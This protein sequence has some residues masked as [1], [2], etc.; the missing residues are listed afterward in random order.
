MSTTISRD[1]VITSQRFVTYKFEHSKLV[2]QR[3]GLRFVNPH[4][5]CVQYELLV[6]SQVQRHVKRLDES[7]PAIGITA[8][9][10]L[11]H[12]RHN[13]INPPLAGVNGG[14]TQEK[15]MGAN[16]NVMIPSSFIN[17]PTPLSGAEVYAT[18]LRC[19]ACLVIAGLIADGVTTIH[20]IYHI[21]RGYEHIDE[22]LTALGAK[23]W[24]ETVE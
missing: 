12:P 6:H 14:Y 11:R 7:I 2:C 16:I 5:W 20:N 23:I 19:G 9:I 1:T 13:M 18:D 22:K 24:R 10:G 4:Q 15:Q 21:E 3:P 8:E 17:G